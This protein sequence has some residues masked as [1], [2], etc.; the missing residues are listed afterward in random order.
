MSYKY[1]VIKVL[2]C[3][4]NDLGKLKIFIVG[5]LDIIKLNLISMYCVLFI[6]VGYRFFFC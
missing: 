4:R 6:Y 3:C 2:S 5:Y 1:L